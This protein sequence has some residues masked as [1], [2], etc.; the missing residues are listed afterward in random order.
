VRSARLA[1]VA[2]GLAV[3]L[4]ACSIGKRDLPLEPPPL[5][6]LEEPLDRR[7]EPRD[8]DARGELAAGSFT[9]LTVGTASDSLDALAS[10]AGGLAVRAIVENSP[11]DFAGAEVGDLVVE[12]RAQDV[13]SSP[14]WPSEWRAIELATPPNTEVTLV[15]DR[16]GAEREL[17][18]TTM[19]RVRPAE[20]EAAQRFREESRVG[21]VL[22]TATEVEARAAGLGPG[23]GAVV[24]GLSRASPWRTA[25]IRYGDLVRAVDGVP[26][27]HPQVVLD[28][29]RGAPDGGELKLE[30]VR[31]GATLTVAAGVS[32][33]AGEVREIDIP[34]L[35]SYSFDRGRSETS[36]LFG[37]YHF[38]STPAAWRLRLLWFI[39]FE[40]GDADR[41][42]AE[43]SSVGVDAA[44]ASSVASDGR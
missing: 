32:E 23:G 40:G 1:L 14:R 21:V 9:G 28:A 31:A 42:E 4:C 27:A 43:E 41:L 38:D 26:V 7:E 22:R 37:L 11:A 35:Y 24:V 2:A 44:P 25:G 5:A 6:D 3:Q 15:V 18:L 16:A 20:R 34:L 30:I 10:D 29:I 17:T 12:V 19:A 13:V 39:E 8:E 33:R 36:F